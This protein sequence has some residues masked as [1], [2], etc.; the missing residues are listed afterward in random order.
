VTTDGS[1]A[2]INIAAAVTTI[3]TT[4]P[5][6]GYYALINAKAPSTT[7][8]LNKDI[9]NAGNSGWIGNLN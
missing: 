8:S 7:V 4:E 6:T 2:G 9:S 1:N 5:T 3:G